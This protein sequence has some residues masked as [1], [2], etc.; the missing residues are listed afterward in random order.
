MIQHVRQYTFNIMNGLAEGA[1]LPSEEN[2]LCPN[3]YSEIGLPER[4]TTINNP[5]C[6]YYKLMVL[7]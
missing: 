5:S 2:I 3:F 6:I 7:F 4:C 1:V